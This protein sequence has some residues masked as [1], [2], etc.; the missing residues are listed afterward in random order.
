M[1]D[2]SSIKTT[3]MSSNWQSLCACLLENNDFRSRNPTLYRIRNISWYYERNFDSNVIPYEVTVVVNYF[4]FSLKTRTYH[5]YISGFFRQCIFVTT[6]KSSL[7]VMRT[8]M[9]QLPCVSIPEDVEPYRQSL[10]G[11]ENLI[12]T[13][14]LYLIYDEISVLPLRVV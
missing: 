12:C 3:P 5:V 8:E 13:L 14:S 6:V 9:I 2:K 11:V 4:T 10:N 1:K 7:R